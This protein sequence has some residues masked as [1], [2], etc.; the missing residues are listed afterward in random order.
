MSCAH[1][2]LS[3]CGW[4]R[5]PL[6][7]TVC[8]FPLSVNSVPNNLDVLGTLAAIGMVDEDDGLVEGAVSELTSMDL[9]IK[10]SYERGGDIDMLL[11]LIDLAEEPVSLCF[12]CTT[13]GASEPSLVRTQEKVD[14][15]LSRL[16]DATMSETPASIESHLTYTEI[17]VRVAASS[18]KKDRADEAY[19][20]AQK[21]FALVNST[22]GGEQHYDRSM[23]LLALSA[24]MSGAD[25]APGE[26]DGMDPG[27]TQLGSRAAAPSDLGQR[28]LHAAPSAHQNWRTA[29]FVRA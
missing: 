7:D 24:S 3:R 4:S 15:A 28:A 13:T 25:Q 21:A 22:E 5:H 17:L 26:V 14:A 2:F 27:S 18:E 8:A 1:T 10:K 12:S 6:V 23:R 19:L 11:A 9:S 16:R 20:A 29:A